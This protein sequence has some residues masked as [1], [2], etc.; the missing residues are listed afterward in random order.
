MGPD[1]AGSACGH[2]G[3]SQLTPHSMPKR[4]ARNVSRIGIVTVPRDRLGVLMPDPD[5]LGD[6]VYK[7]QELACD[8][9]TA[10]VKL[11]AGKPSR[12]FLNADGLGEQATLKVE[13]LDAA[14]K[15]LPGLSG[16]AAAVVKQS[17]FQTPV[18]FGGKA[19]I[20]GLPDRVRVRITYR[21]ERMK[22]IRFS[23]LYVQ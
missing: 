3:F 19:E 21:G 8:L 16:D 14:L 7:L 4:R 15:P 20:A 6:S 5:T 12:F 17:G 13:L 11:K 18:T 1:A 10:P 22:E 2:A 9:V 23:A